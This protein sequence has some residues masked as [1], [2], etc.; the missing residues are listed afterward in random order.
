LGAQGTVCAGGRYDGLIEQL[1]GREN[2][3]VGFAMGMERLLALCEA[4]GSLEVSS[5][6]D[7]YLVRV[8]TAA[9]QAGMRLAEQLRDQLPRMRL[10]LH[11]G[12]GSFKSQFKKADKSGADY[13][14]IIGD[15]EAG[16]GEISIKSLRREQPQDTIPAA[17][18]AAYFARRL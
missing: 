8:G 13:A 9:E 1:G 7:I 6:I 3:A 5:G 16:R 17:D 14:I 18:A 15:D 10:Q 4:R 12:G 11:C 2:H